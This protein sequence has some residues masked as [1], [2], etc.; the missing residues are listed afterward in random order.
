[1]LLLC[2]LLHQVREWREESRQKTSADDG[3]ATLFFFFFPRLLNGGLDVSGAEGESEGNDPLRDIL[4][5]LLPSPS[6]S[7]SASSSASASASA[8]TSAST[9]ASAS[10]SSMSLLPLCFENMAACVP[11]MHFNI[12]TTL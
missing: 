5:L 6:P 2:V 9:S 12:P 4:L 8:S 11:S 1:M 7:S 10:S 3:G